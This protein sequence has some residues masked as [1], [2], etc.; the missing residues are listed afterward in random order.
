MSG[1]PVTIG[2]WQVDPAAN[3]ISGPA[4][5]AELE[6]RV[7]DLLMLF[8]AQPGRVF[9][10][11]EIAT[12]LWGSI[13]VNDDALTR[14]IFKL[15]KA[16]GDD[17]RNARYIAT[18]PK[19]GYRLVAE[20]SAPGEETSQPTAGRRRAW[21]AAAAGLALV[22]VAALGW[23]MTR[24]A[25]TAPGTGPQAER[26]TRADGFYFQFTRTDNEAA[27]RLYEGVLEEDPDNA[28]ALAGL[29]NTLTQR[30]IRYQGADGE[31][32]GRTSLTEALESGWLDTPEARAGLERAAALARRASEAD[33]SHPRAWRALGLA[34]AAGRDFDQAERAYERA[35]VIDPD[36]WG[37]MINL[38]ELNTL[39]GRSERATPYLEQA[40]LAME[41]RYGE[42]PVGIRPWHSAVGLAVADA[43][44]EAGVPQEAE[45]WYRR[46]LALD[47]LNPDAVR[48]LA[49]LLVQYGDQAGADALCSEL[50]RAS[51]E[52]C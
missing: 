8:A 22:L 18:V 2:E 11:D 25:G 27:L 38:S 37:T 36:D 4:G 1:E 21:L 13:H 51:G 9:S 32:A 40:W 35:L 7:M 26:L 17:A 5:A 43:K 10:R 46:V 14:S 50:A 34:L 45:L 15:R 39:T 31:G 6:P 19:R 42:D 33:P 3:R 52:T 28:A 47:P 24:E 12:A 29:A 23:G 49:G 30:L 44:V 20:V 41:R 16:L 48:G